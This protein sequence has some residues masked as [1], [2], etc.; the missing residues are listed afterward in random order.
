ME[1]WLNEVCDTYIHPLFKI[2][3]SQSNGLRIKNVVELCAPDVSR[4][5]GVFAIELY[6]QFWSRDFRGR[7]SGIVFAAISFPLDE[8]LESSLVPTTV[9]YL[10]YFPL[11]FSIDDYGRW[12]VLHLPVC[13]WVVRGWSKLHYVEHWMEL[14][15][16][17]WQL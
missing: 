2:A 15:H 3:M 1:I 4:S 6:C 11:H 10:F 7:L 14:L 9:E 8:V 13:N 17:V 12:V 16:L 5:P